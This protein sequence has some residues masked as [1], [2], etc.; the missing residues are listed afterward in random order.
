MDAIILAGGE[1]KR[2]PVI[3]GFL[4]ISSKRII[5]KNI[6]LL[7]GIF[8]RVIIS[9]NNPELYFYL[10][11]PMVGDIIGY[12]GPMTGIFSALTIPEVSGIFV[13]ACDMP[14]INTM[15]IKYIVDKW[16][17]R[18]DAVIPI[19]DKKPQPLLGIYSKRI[20]K[21]MEQSIKNGER[22]LRR[23]LQGINVLYINED[24]LREI[25]PEGRSFININTMEDFQKEIGGNI[26]LV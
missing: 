15:L 25:D 24:E 3:K 2:F 12:R 17:E 21:R 8:D 1:N 13:T 22:S 19:F 14:F 11:V 5:E 16:E 4:E 26:C 9:T 10:S 23:F 6:E 18:W 7:K 20:D